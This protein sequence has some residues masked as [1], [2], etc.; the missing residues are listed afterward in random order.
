MPAKKDD[1][2]IPTVPIH[3]S[4]K[5]HECPTGEKRPQAMAYAFV[6]SG[7]LAAKAAVDEKGAATLTVP[8]TQSPQE[9]RVVVGPEI[10]ESRK[11]TVSE[12]T[13]RGSLETFLRVGAEA[14]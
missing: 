13:R 11:V 8:A 14:E 4:V 12:L 1:A 10:D 7:R 2:T 3:V 6:G 5:L 9:V